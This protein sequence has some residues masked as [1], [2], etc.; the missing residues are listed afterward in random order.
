[1]KPTQ[2]QTIEP[3]H[4]ITEVPGFLAGTASCDVRQN[5]DYER[6][7]LTVIISKSPCS[8]AGVFTL[9]DVK[10]APVTLCQSL[11]KKTD[12]IHGIVVNSGNANA[13]TGEQG[14][15]DAREMAART[16]AIFK[17][18]AH[19]IFVASTGRIGRPLPMNAIRS[20]ID[21]ASKAANASSENGLASAEAILTS[22]TRTKTAAYS[23]TS[24]EG[25]TITLAG[26]A[27][28]AGMIEPNMATMLAFIG[29]DAKIPQTLLQSTLHQSVKNSFNRIS[30]DGDMSTNDTVLVLANG[31]SGAVIDSEDNPDFATFLEALK[32][33]CFDL[34]Y[35]IVSDGE[36]ITKVVTL[37]IKGAPT[38]EAAQ[39]VARAV[40][41]SLLVK[42]SWYGSDPN[43][44]R[45]IDA[46]GYAQ[47][48]I[49]INKV[50]LAYDDIPALTHGTPIIENEGKWKQIVAQKE[51]TISLNLNLGNQ[52]TQLLST[53][54]TEAYV[55]FNR[56]E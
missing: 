50:D 51:F 45:V 29:T 9:N 54:L 22:D 17:I 38:A 44:G 23:F 32:K 6:K 21:A 46:A 43:W 41:N 27:K 10:A 35:K 1:M 3:A 42:S 11:L 2:I 52:E 48:G 14:D 12:A 8:A 25:Q 55:N 20:G 39:K 49:D 30:V 28:G 53:D 16:Q 40:G 24:S 5:G 31:D 47:I 18:P 19:S 36:K 15:A 56:S 37:Q 33:V 26:I 13:V 4:G 34:A 7:D